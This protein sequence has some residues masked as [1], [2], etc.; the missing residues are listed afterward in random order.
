VQAE[1]LAPQLFRAGANTNR[2][3]EMQGRNIRLCVWYAQHSSGNTI[4]AFDHPRVQPQLER[5]DPTTVVISLDFELI[6]GYID[7]WYGDDLVEMGRWTHDV[8]VPNL[9]NHFTR[10]AFRQLGHCW[11][12]GAFLVARRFRSS[13]SNNRHFPN[14]GS[15]M[16]PK[17]ATNRLIPSGSARA[18]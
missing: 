15:V 14:L 13:R 7:L 11:C 1:A 2:R 12:D 6:W 4:H 3:R 5:N 16:F 18:W 10:T 9:L 8:G 17:K